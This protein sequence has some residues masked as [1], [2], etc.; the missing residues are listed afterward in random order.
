MKNL[1]I[2][3]YA[4]ALLW[5]ASC[6]T[7]SRMIGEIDHK[8]PSMNINTPEVLI[9]PVIADLDIIQE[10]KSVTYEADLELNPSEFKSNAKA[11]FLK[12]HNCDVIINPHYLKTTKIENS[13]VVGVTYVVSGFPATFKKIYQ[14]EKLEES[15][16]DYNTMNVDVKREDFTALDKVGKKGSEL[17][18]SLAGGNY[19]GVELGYFSDITKGVYYFGSVETY[20]A[21][22]QINFDI[23]DAKNG[24]TNQRSS[25]FNMSSFS[26]GA[27]YRLP[28]TKHM[29][30]SIFG[31]LNVAN[32]AF[33]NPV[34]S[35]GNNYRIEGFTTI[36]LRAGVQFDQDIYRNISWFGKGFANI[37]FLPMVNSSAEGDGFEVSNV[38]L[39]EGG[40]L[41]NY[42]LGLRFR[43]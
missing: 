25:A 10:K 11:S 4:S 38:T 35:F 30:S 27:G 28:L 22:E 18:L 2:T 14:T 20:T 16:R 12:E 41:I 5:L 39:P 43:F 1:N 8:A 15:V 13:N 33:N 36:G 40:Q 37:H 17:Y 23:T 31:G 7:E 21:N 24:N 34:T 9:K 6:G 32:M 3:F 26:L 42:A 19:S 29:N